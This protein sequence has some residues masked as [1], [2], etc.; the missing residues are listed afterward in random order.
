MLEKNLL[1]IAVG[2]GGA[3][4]PAMARVMISTQR[5]RAASVMG[6]ESMLFKL[7][8]GAFDVGEIP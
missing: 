1:G 6:K 2:L 8:K 3:Q 7:R 4:H 5:L